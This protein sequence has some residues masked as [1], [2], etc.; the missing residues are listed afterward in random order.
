M[1]RGGTR[2]EGGVSGVVKGRRVFARRQF[3]GPAASAGEG[4]D[5]RRDERQEVAKEAYLRAICG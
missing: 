3:R 4:A 5:D 2:A 1:E